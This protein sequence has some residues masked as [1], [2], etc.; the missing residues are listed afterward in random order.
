[1]TRTRP[2]LRRTAGPAAAALL[3][4]GFAFVDAERASGALSD[5]FPD[6]VPICKGA[7]GK[8]GRDGRLLAMSAQLASLDGL[9]RVADS[10]TGSLNTEDNLDLFEKLG[11][12]EGHLVIGKALLDARM[13]DDALPHFGHPVRELYDYLKPVFAERKY[14]EFERQLQELEHRATEAPNEAATAAAFDDVISRIDGLRRSIPGALLGSADFLIMGIALMVDDAAGDLGESLDKGRIANTV[15]YHDAMGFARYADGAVRSYAG[16]LG[17]RADALAHETA[18]T[19]SAFP[20]LKPP[21]H[22]V[23]SVGDLR[24][25]AERVKASAKTA[26]ARAG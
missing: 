26:P 25:A 8:L 2:L 13:Q 21:S 15:E 3:I 18:F 12:M 1:M 17:A 22:P 24:D 19:L 23:R 20:S 16:I 11:L 5:G 4:A 9:V 7:D 10:T 6:A 14:P